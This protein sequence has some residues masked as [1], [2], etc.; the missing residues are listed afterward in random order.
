MVIIVSCQPFQPDEHNDKTTQLLD[1]PTPLATWNVGI[2]I[3]DGVY[4]TELTAPMDIFHHTVFHHDL[5]MKVFTIADSKAP[6]RTF[7]GLNILADYNYL[8]DSL[9]PIHVL[10]VPSAEHHLD[11][12]LENETLIQF[13]REAGKNANYVMSLCDGAF[14]LAK[15]G[16]LDDSASTTFPGDIDAYKKMFPHLIVHKDVLFVHDGKFITSAGGAKSFEPALYL[17]ELLYGKKAADGIAKGMV[18]DWNLDEVPKVIVKK[19]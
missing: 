8:T 1:S 3:M 18:I 14:V 12:D 16:L 13:V 17:S 9:P 10:V 15:A 11:T 19:N 2:L 7:E 4:N 5:G 6:I